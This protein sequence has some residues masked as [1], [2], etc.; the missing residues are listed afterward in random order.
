M[1][2]SNTAFMQG[3][4]ENTGSGELN[5]LILECCP[6]RVLVESGVCS[7]WQVILREC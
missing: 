5:Q 7:S 2:M 4:V 6:P 3:K 1:T